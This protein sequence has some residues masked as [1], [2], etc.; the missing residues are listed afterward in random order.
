LAQEIYDM[1]KNNFNTCLIERNPEPLP[2]KLLL[3]PVN[4]LSRKPDS[5]WKVSDVLPLAKILTGRIAIDGSGENHQGADA[6]MKIGTDLT[7]YIFAH[8]EIRFIINP[9]YVVLDFTTINE[10]VP[11]K[12]NAYPSVGSLNFYPGS[13]HVFSFNDPGVTESTYHFIRWLQGFYPRI[14]AFV[15]YTAYATGL[16]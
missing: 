3:E 6:L 14:R 15:F 12:V 9:L 1:Y 13:N 2:G 4:I 11:P 7:T 16:Y 8:P 5:E 10:N